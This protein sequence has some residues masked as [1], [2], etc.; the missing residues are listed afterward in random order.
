MINQVWLDQQIGDANYWKDN[1]LLQ[2][3]KEGAQHATWES[4]RIYQEA[5][6]RGET[7]ARIF[8]VVERQDKE[9]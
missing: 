2:A 6:V 3:L 8:I 4:N 1:L 9:E 7:W 5:E